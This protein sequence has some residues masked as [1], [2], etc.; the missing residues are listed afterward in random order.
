SCG[1]SR[2]LAGGESLC[3][4][5]AR[6]QRPG[7]AYDSRVRVGDQLG[8]PRSRRGESLLGPLRRLGPP[9]ADTIALLPYTALQ[10]IADLANP[11][12]GGTGGPP[13]TCP[14]CHPGSWARWPTR[15]SHVWSINEQCG[16]ACGVAPVR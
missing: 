16:C 2:A 9:A 13:P 15:F 1:R 3:P 10:A 6:V 5:A 12:R 7:L 14:R 11:P 4:A 8:V